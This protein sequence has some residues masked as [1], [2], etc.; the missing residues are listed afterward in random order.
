MWENSH[1]TELF[2]LIFL[3]T[4]WAPTPAENETF[5]WSHAISDSLLKC[6]FL[7]PFTKKPFHHFLSFHATST[8]SPSYTF[9]YSLSSSLF[10]TNIPNFIVLVLLTLHP[11]GMELSGSAT[12]LVS[13]S[14]GCFCKRRMSDLHARMCLCGVLDDIDRLKGCQHVR[15]VTNCPKDWRSY[16]VENNLQPW[17]SL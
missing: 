1:G 14:I 11:T 2:P 7:F 8:S 17:F 13:L 6:F 5:N 12:D 10:Q 9:S 3:V 15:P 16:F 4:R